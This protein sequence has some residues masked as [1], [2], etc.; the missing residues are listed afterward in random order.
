MQEKSKDIQRKVVGRY[1]F[2]A[3]ELDPSE[4]QLYEHG[5]AIR[6]QPKV[7]DALLILVDNAGRLVRRDELVDTL[8]PETFVT[9]ANLTNVMVTLRKI[10]GREAIQTVSKFGYRFSMPVLGEPG[11][12]QATYETFRRAKALVETKSLDAMQQARELF[13]VCVAADPGFA[14]AWAWLGRSARFLDKFKAAD[15]RSRRRARELRRA[16]SRVPVLRPAR[17]IARGARARRRSRS[18]GRDQRPPHAFPSGRL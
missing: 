11:I 15:H 4:R 14:A 13:S 3:F 12:D 5:R 8:W 10:L 1:R 9:D 7:F 17:P 2:G 16:G 6:L 18:D